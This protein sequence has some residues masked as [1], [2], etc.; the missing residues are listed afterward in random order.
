MQL[1]FR[2]SVIFIF[3]V[4]TTSLMFGLGSKNTTILRNSAS[5]LMNFT[6]MDKVC[7]IHTTL[8]LR[9]I[10]SIETTFN[11]TKQSDS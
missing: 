5:K 2:F 8:F 10:N 4:K 9:K 7:K 1:K 11:L 3:G 6:Y